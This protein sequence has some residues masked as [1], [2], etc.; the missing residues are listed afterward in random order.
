MAY[1]PTKKEIFKESIGN[2]R[3]A[4]SKAYNYL[5]KDIKDPNLR[6]DLKDFCEGSS[7]AVMFVVTPTY[8]RRLF[9]RAITKGLNP[10]PVAEKVGSWAGLGVFGLE[11][12][13]TMGMDHNTFGRVVSTL[14]ATNAIS[15]AYEIGRKITSDSRER[16]IQ[17][18]ELA[19]RVAE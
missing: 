13:Y 3:E 16:L 6:T 4:I 9:Q 8:L 7:I 1:E 17:R 5:H 15:G 12:F 11:T 14:I 19:D 18:S 2:M 10:Q